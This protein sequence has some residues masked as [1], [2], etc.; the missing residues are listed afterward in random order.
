MAFQVLSERVACWTQGPPDENVEIAMTYPGWGQVASRARR[1][2]RI[3][4][5]PWGESSTGTEGN[6]RVARMQLLAYARE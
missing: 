6:R 2:G 4:G 3:D 5:T 1:D